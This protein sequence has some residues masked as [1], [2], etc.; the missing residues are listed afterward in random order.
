MKLT[1]PWPNGSSLRPN[2]GSIRSIVTPGA[3][4]GTS[5]IEWREYRCASGSVRPMKMATLQFGCPTP[6]ENHF[7]PLSTTSSPSTTAVAAMFVAS[8]EATSGSVM[9]NA[10]RISPRSNGAS[11]RCFCSALPNR[12]S[13]SMLPVS[14]ALQLKISGAMNE[15]PISSASGAYSTLDSPAPCSSSGRNRFH[16]PR[17]RALAFSSSMTGRTTHGSARPAR[18]RWTSSSTGSISSRMKSPTLRM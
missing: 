1:S 18:S 14:G 13:T 3:S 9:Q 6:V 2:T 15:R 11:H 12:C 8:E 10:D 16:R 5:T 7:R 17:S 4:I